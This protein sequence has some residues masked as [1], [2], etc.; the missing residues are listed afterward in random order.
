MNDLA[1][2][3]A[4]PR[5]S[6]EAAKTGADG[7]R[8]ALDRGERSWR[9]LVLRSGDLGG[10]QLSASDFSQASLRRT[11][12]DGADLSG[13]SFVETDL[14]RASFVGCVLVGASFVGADLRGAD[15]RH[16]DLTRANLSHADLRLA[17]VRGCCLDGATI[18]LGCSTFHGVQLDGQ[19]LRSLFTLMLAARCEDADVSAALASLAPG[20]TAPMVAPAPEAE[21]CPCGPQ[22]GGRQ[23]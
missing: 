17:D 15:L 1:A 5:A 22:P 16:A 9:G 19:A 4:P 10:L 13:A 3:G 14:R 21:A 2:L 6:A 7:V 11:R 18:T 23:P 20:L 12:F 8:A